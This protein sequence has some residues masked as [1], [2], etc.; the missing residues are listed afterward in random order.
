MSITLK[1]I[2]KNDI[3]KR[4]NEYVYNLI[5]VFSLEVVCCHIYKSKF[6]NIELLKKL[7]ITILN[8]QHLNTNLI[9]NNLFIK[10]IMHNIGKEIPEYEVYN[11][12]KD[13]NTEKFKNHICDTNNHTFSE[14]TC[15]FSIYNSFEMCL[16]HY[17]NDNN[18]NYNSYI[19]EYF[20]RKYLLPET[21]QNFKT[22]TLY[23]MSGSNKT[24]YLEE[25]FDN[26]D[27]YKSF[28][29][30]LNNKKKLAINNSLLWDKTLLSQVDISYLFLNDFKKQVH[31]IRSESIVYYNYIYKIY[32]WL[33]WCYWN[34]N[35]PFRKKKLSNEY[36]SFTNV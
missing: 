10:V 4:F 23:V 25:E 16:Y 8:N 19:S 7:Y 36:D 21:Y 35:S 6:I 27:R 26:S 12:I 3:N 33:Y 18:I 5:E 24:H 30:V 1:S 22:N 13:I 15:D 34:P 31:I 28:N 17:L 14:D 11:L 32:N 2:I 29:S 20:V 9:L